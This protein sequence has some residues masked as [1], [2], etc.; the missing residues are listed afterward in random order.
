MGENRPVSGHRQLGRMMG[1]T[2]LG[3][4]CARKSGV[5]FKQQFALADPLAV[6]DVN[7]P[8]GADLYCLHGFD[9]GGR[10]DLPGCIRDHIDAPK[11]GPQNCDGKQQAQCDQQQTG[12]GAWRGFKDLKR[13]RKELGILDGAFPAILLILATPGFAQHVDMQPQ[14]RAHLPQPLKPAHATAPICLAWSCA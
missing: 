11:H 14:P 5:Q 1:L 8:H 13:G 10:D 9:I 4:I 3:F 12:A 7:R 6:A 2:G